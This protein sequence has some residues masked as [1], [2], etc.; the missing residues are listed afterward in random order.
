M[1]GSIIPWNGIIEDRSFYHNQSGS[2]DG[3]AVLRN[4]LSPY[5]LNVIVDTRNDTWFNLDTVVSKVDGGDSKENEG[6]FDLSD[7]FNRI[8][9]EMENEKKENKGVKLQHNPFPILPSFID[10]EDEDLN[11]DQGEQDSS[12]WK[13]EEFLFL[14]CYMI[15]R[16]NNAY[17]PVLSSLRDKLNAII[18]NHNHLTEEIKD[19]TNVFFF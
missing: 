17:D 11:L 1:Y 16:D 3:L 8:L 15:F 12:L 6:S 9:H 7:D 2:R 18:D 10:A 13:Q 4:S 5:P 14:N 19:I